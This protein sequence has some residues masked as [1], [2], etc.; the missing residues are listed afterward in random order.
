MRKRRRASPTRTATVPVKSAWKS[1]IIWTYVASLIASWA[2]AKG[3]DMGADTQVA[4][5]LFLQGAAGILIWIWRTWFNGS[6]SP[7]SLGK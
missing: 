7:A 5:V 4:V 2:A 1:K 3:F 6:V